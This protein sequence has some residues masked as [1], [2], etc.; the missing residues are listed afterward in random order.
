M[1]LVCCVPNVAILLAV[2]ALV[3]APAAWAR[4][5]LADAV[6]IA[7]AV[8]L[9]RHLLVLLESQRGWISAHLLVDMSFRALCHPMQYSHPSISPIV[10]GT[11][12]ISCRLCSHVAQASAPCPARA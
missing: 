2:V 3:E 9:R 10:P 1:R 12:G 11:G 5:S 6:W 4:C 8:P 7:Q